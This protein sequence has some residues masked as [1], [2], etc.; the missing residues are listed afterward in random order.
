LID[1]AE[2]AAER[3]RGT[4][5]VVDRP[6]VDGHLLRFEF[7]GDFKDQAALVGWLVGEG[8]EVVEVIAHKKSLEDVFLQVTEGLVQ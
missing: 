8:F 3:L 6:L 2:Q 7:A 4:M 5:G 1:R